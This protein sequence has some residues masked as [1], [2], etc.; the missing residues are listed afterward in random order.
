MAL[1]VSYIMYSKS[2]EVSLE[3]RLTLNKQIS[4]RPRSV[5][6]LRCDGQLEAIDPPLLSDGILTAAVLRVDEIFRIGFGARRSACY[7]CPVPRS[8][9]CSIQEY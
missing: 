6:L 7:R 1:G 3:G 5:E 9:A 4:D 8:T 2:V